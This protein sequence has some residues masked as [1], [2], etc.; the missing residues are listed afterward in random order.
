MGDQYRRALKK[1]INIDEC[2]IS[3]QT[4][5][6]KNCNHRRVWEI[7]IDE[8]S[9]KGLTQM[10]VGDKWKRELENNKHGQVWEINPDEHWKKD[11]HIQVLEPI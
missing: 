2:W 6:G 7:N 9:K 8:H 1:G 5:I 10:S 4:R 11:R 3:M